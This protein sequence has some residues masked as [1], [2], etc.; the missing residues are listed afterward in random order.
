NLY[1][2]QVRLALGR[3]VRYT[4]SAYPPTAATTY[5]S[6]TIVDSGQ[7]QDAGGIAVNRA[8]DHLLAAARAASDG[9]VKEYSSAAEGN[10]L[11]REIGNGVINPIGGTAQDV[12]VNAATGDIFVAGVR[13]GAKTDLTTPEEPF[14]SGVYV[15][16]ADGKLKTTI[17]GSDTPAEGFRS[18]SG[19][20]RSA[21]DEA[22]GEVFVTDLLGSK[23]AYRF[24]PD[25]KGSYEYVADP[26]LE[27]HSYSESEPGAVAVVNHPGLPNSR[28][29]YITSTGNIGHLYAFTRPSEGGP[30]LT[31]DIEGGSGTVVSNPAGIEC[32]G[33]E[34][35]SCSTEAIEEGTVTLTASPAPGYL[36]MSWKH[37]DAGGVNGRQCTIALDE[38]KQVGVRFVRAWSLEGS[39]AGGL[40]ILSTSPGGLSCSYACGSSTALYRE[41]SVTLK[42]KPARHFHFVEFTGGTGSAGG[43]NGVTTETCTIAI[44]SDSSIKAVYAEDAKNTLSLAKTGGGQGFVKTEPAGINCGPA[45]ASVQ[46]QFFASESP[47]VTVTLGKGTSSVT[48]VVGA[49][50][51]T[52]N[53]LTCTVPTS[54]SHSL[55]AKFD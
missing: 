51:C 53:A 3:V 38:A 18:N 5:G 35:K 55:V 24:V 43:C 37:C 9:Y 13:P 32:T 47:T 1:V 23:R 6:P 45:C 10:T 20:L 54:S 39:K 7:T 4:P 28:N 40:G 34:G 50:T 27:S 48:W 42:A 46:A 8:N 16:G 2:S 15:F 22:S 36:L 41:G 17:E 29:V 12:A 31:V 30:P 26:E 33:S 25:G 21:I 44:A 52:G 14:V 49:G 19:K 11:L